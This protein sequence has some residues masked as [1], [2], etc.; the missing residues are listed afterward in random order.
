MDA[1]DMRAQV[2]C[3]SG[4]KGEGLLR[5]SF[6]YCVILPVLTIMTFKISNPEVKKNSAV[7]H[8]GESA[9]VPRLICK[10]WMLYKYSLMIMEGIPYYLLF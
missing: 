2:H 5:T 4:E 6:A 3:S 1:F 7:Y 9:I 8:S 10:M